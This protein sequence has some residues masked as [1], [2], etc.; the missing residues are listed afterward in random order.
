MRKIISG[1][2]ENLQNGLFILYLRNQIQIQTNKNKNI[3][4][5]MASHGYSIHDFRNGEILKDLM[6]APENNTVSVKPL[7]VHLLGNVHMSPHG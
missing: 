4:Y 3:F 7:Q 6:T 2:G 1:R 5:L